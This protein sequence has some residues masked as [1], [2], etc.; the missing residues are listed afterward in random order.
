MNVSPCHF[1]VH[2]HDYGTRV[3]DASERG[4]VLV[5]FWSA[6]IGSCKP[7]IERLARLCTEQQGRFLLA[8]CNTDEE[9]GLTR[10][11]GVDAPPQVRLIHRRKVIE[12]VHDAVSDETL[13]DI[14]SQHLTNILR[15]EHIEAL[16]LLKDGQTGQA[17][18]KLTDAQ[19]KTPHDS[20]ITADLLRL[21]VLEQRLDEAERLAGGLPDN[22]LQD[23]E[24]SKLCAHVELI[25]ASKSP[26]SDMP[27]LIMNYYMQLEESPDQPEMR[28]E[29][30]SILVKIDDIESAMEQL[31][32][33]HQHDRGFR[34]DIGQRG[35]MALFSMLDDDDELVKKYRGKLI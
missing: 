20:R 11:L 15:P 34:N 16:D 14:L 7:Q 12:T 24:L 1:D 9:P 17:L 32:R 26:D 31:Y 2:E 23:T 29:L 35:M 33:I 21:L 27:K 28:L 6:G 22:L 13:G 8:L 18:D 5:Y 4:L 30:A 10:R 25:T 19:Q 3:L